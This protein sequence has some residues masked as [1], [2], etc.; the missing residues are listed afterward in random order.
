MIGSLGVLG[1][2]FCLD[3]FGFL[4]ITRGLHSSTFRLNVSA[5]CGTEGT[6]KGCLCG[7]SGGLRGCLGCISCQKRLKLS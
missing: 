2:L 3:S 1:T 4:P 5:F 6:C 7:G